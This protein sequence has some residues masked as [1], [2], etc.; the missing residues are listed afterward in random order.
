M[1]GIPCSACQWVANNAQD[2][3]AKDGCGWL[4][5]ND[6]TKICDSALGTGILSGICVAA[7]MGGCSN[8]AKQI[9]NHVFTPLGACQTL[10][11]C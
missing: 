7:F 3:I 11:M 8:F 6:I 1:T 10:S 2:A 9:E 5:K 4:F